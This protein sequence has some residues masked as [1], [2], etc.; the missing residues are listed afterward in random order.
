MK[1]L[2]CTVFSCLSFA[3][4]SQLPEVYT[5]APN[6]GRC[7]GT[8]ILYPNATYV[9]QSGCEAAPRLSFGK[10]MIKNDTIKLQ[11]VDPK[12][13]GVIKNVS[14]TTIPGDSVWVTILDKEGI[15]ITSKISIG[16]EVAG[17]GSYMFG[18]D[19]TGAKKFVYKRSGGNLVLRTLNKLFA[20]KFEWAT[21]TAN[22]FIITLNLSAGWITST[23]AAWGSPGGLSLLKKG[24][25]LTGLSPLFP[26]RTLF[27][28]KE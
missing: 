16:L 25:T 28:R 2:F 21:D 7:P 24:P 8:I 18:S 22:H 3:L 26:E 27:N 4:Y 9:Y 23:H 12:T 20:Q 6:A 15:N 11:P 19:S 17:R 5:A 14:A 1:F 10:W 13:Y